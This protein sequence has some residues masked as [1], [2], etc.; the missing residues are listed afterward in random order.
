MIA[1]ESTLYVVF[2]GSAKWWFPEM[3]LLQKHPYFNGIFHDKPTIFGCPHSWKPLNQAQKDSNF[4][5]SWV[6]QRLRI[7]KIRGSNS[8]RLRARSLVVSATCAALDYG[9][10]L[11]GRVTLT[12]AGISPTSRGYSVG[13]WSIWSTGELSWSRLTC[14]C[15]HGF[16]AWRNTTNHTLNSTCKAR[17]PPRQV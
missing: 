1:Q 12:E 8:S 11:Q 3:G 14:I 7:Q 10:L 4:G 2:T 17:E 9:E 5:V 6:S 15:F 13:N 16:V